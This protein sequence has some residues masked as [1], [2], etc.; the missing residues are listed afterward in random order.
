M[1]QKTYL[2]SLE[3][4]HPDLAIEDVDHVSLLVRDLKPEP[5]PDGAMPRSPELLVHRVL[6][7]LGGCLRVC[8]Y[9]RYT[10]SSTGRVDTAGNSKLFT[11]RTEHRVL[12]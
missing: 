4:Q 5:L 3:G 6:Y 10:V 8:R 12:S 11:P 1:N 9:T 2:R 7:Q